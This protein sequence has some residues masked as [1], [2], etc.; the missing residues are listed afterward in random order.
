VPAKVKQRSAKL[1]SPVVTNPR[2]VSPAAKLGA[3]AA[4]KVGLIVPAAIVSVPM[5]EK[6]SGLAAALRAK[7]MT[8]E[9]VAFAEPLA[10]L[11]AK[12]MGNAAGA[13]NTWAN[14][15]FSVKM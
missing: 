3:D 9:P 4:T 10:W 1:A 5:L 8:G 15:A 2:I 6:L 13:A 7:V 12:L 14:T 11:P